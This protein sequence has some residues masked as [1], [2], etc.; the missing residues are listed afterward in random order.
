MLDAFNVQ[1]VYSNDLHQVTIH[2][3]LTDAT[4]QAIT[5]LLTDPRTDQATPLT[6]APATQD[7]SSHLAA[8]TGIHA[9]APNACKSCA[10]SATP[11]VAMAS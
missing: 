8:D 7:H 1:A 5:G 10:L 2:A 4:P 6:P 11:Q 3:T 9:L